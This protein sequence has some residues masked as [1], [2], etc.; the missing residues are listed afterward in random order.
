[1]LVAVSDFEAVNGK[2]VSGRVDGDRVLAGNAAMQA[3]ARID[4]SAFAGHAPAEMIEAL[5]TATR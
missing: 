3:D 5:R 2:G 4:T 1:M